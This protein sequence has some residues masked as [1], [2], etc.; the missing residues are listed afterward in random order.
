MLAPTGRALPVRDR[1]EALHCIDSDLVVALQ[2][3]RSDLLFVHAA[4]LARAGRVC[5]LAAA[6]GTGK[7]TTAWGLLHHGFSYASDELS[8]VDVA[9]LRVLPY[10]RAICLKQSPPAPYD[11]PPSAVR[12]GTML[13][14]PPQALPSPVVGG[15]RPLAAVFVL[16]RSARAAD[17]A[18]RALG[19]AEAAARLY[20]TTLNALAHP[21]RGLASVLRLARSVP[22]FRFSLGALDRSCA[23]IREVFDSLAPGEARGSARGSPAARLLRD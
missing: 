11:V 13:F 19:A 15:A 3:M 8:A 21:D 9:E 1:R 10:P 7:S 2:R 16:E 23:L 12:A 6:S 17:P 14:L 20:A 5:L 4:A 18:A 22:C